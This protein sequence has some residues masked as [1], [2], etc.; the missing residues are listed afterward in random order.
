MHRY[1]FFPAEQK[2]QS[3]CLGKI[4]DT[5]KMLRSIVFFVAL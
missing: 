4:K 5:T 2:K 1:N 3:N